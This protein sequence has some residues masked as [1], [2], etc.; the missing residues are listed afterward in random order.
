MWVGKGL[1]VGYRMFD[2]LYFASYIYTFIGDI[3]RY[4]H[5]SLSGSYPCFFGI[6]RKNI[7]HIK[8]TLLLPSVACIAISM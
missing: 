7:F 4:I 1:H 6:L 3:T 8:E 2:T 5:T